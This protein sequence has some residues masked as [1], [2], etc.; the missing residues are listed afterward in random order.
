M[1]RP[2]S[3]RNLKPLDGE[4]L[5]RL[6]IGYV[7]RYATTRAKLAIYLRRKLGERGWAEAEEG[8][9]GGGMARIDAI[10]ARFADV[11]YVDD[12]GFAEARAA[13]YA[14]RGY[15]ARRLSERLRADGIAEEDA[16]TAHA[17]AD[18]NAWAAAL[19]FARKRRI[20][21]FARTEGDPD[22]RRRALGAM[23]RAG[24]AMDVARRIVNAAPD[25]IPDEFA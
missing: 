4:A 18:D 7:G 17:A 14:R 12:R 2:S 25:E 24:H 21:P 6:A 11:G 22:V 10:V 23:L 5:E 16:D 1:A 13:A 19:A 9:E 8:A 15:G 20:G 3:Y